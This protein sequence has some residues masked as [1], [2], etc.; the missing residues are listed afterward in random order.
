M[1]L[2]ELEKIV[3]DLSDGEKTQLLQWVIR[4]LTGGFVGIESHPEILGGDVCI[5]RTRIP[6]WVLAQAKHKF[7]KIIQPYELRI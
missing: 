2:L 7:C 6:V 1:S 4:D 5:V 3:S